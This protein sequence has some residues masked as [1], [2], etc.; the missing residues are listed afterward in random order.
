MKDDLEALL[1]AWRERALRKISAGLNRASGRAST[2]KHQCR[3]PLFWVFARLSP[4]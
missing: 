1:A 3:R 4:P 2:P